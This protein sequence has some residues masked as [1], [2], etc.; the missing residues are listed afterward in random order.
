MNWVLRIAA[1]LLALALLAAPVIAVNYGVIGADRWPLKKMRVMNDL[2]YVD[3]R[4]LTKALKP[5][6]EQG[7]FGVDLDEAQERVKQMP[8]VSNAQVRKKWPDTLEVTVTEDPPLALWGSDKL[9]SKS[10][11][12]FSKKGVRVPA[13]LPQLD[14]N[15]LDVKRVVELYAVSSDL[16]S[17]IKVPL[18]SVQMD[19][20]GSFSVD[21]ANGTHVIAGRN[22]ARARLTRFVSIYPQLISQN[23]ALPRT[24]D[25]RY[26]NG[27]AMS[28]IATT[29]NA[30][31]PAAVAATAT[32]ETP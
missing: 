2:K 14:G 26:T 28:W 25:L 16:F 15:P 22:D 18:K 19:P 6:A 29:N 17:K 10:L 7:F 32:K 24:V 5:Y 3:A 9:V 21:L 1:W 31:A 23:K 27:F 20:R 8:W 30:A 13:N 11:K 12:I 4:D